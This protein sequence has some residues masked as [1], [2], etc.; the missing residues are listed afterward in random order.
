MRGAATGKKPNGT[1]TPEFGHSGSDRT[2]RLQAAAKARRGPAGFGEVASPPSKEAVRRSVE[3]GMCPFCGRGPFKVVS[4]HTNKK[5]GVDKFELRKLAGM[6]RN[7]PTCLPAFSE[8]ASENGRAN[9]ADRMRA[10]ADEHRGKTWAE[11]GGREWTDAGRAKIGESNR[12]R[13]DSMP[14]EER[15]ALIERMARASKTEGA[16]SRHAASL[17]RR[18]ANLTAEER[19]EASAHL[20]AWQTGG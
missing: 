19:R 13:W 15:E 10:L 14:D 8:R 18:W 9:H 16:R 2:S 12:R 7:E 11:R 17:R 5:H 3:A 4:V 20:R 1:G 6:T